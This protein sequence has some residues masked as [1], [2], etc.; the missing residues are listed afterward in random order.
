MF[1]LEPN[2]NPSGVCEPE[3]LTGVSLANKAARQSQGKGMQGL[4]GTLKEKWKGK[5]FLS[6]KS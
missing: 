3:V 2:Y 5:D 4:S 1:E 6:H